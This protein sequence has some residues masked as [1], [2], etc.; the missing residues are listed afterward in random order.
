[1]PTRRDYRLPVEETEIGKTLNCE[2]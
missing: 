2:L 1:M